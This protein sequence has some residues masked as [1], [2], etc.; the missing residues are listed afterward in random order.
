MSPS[1]RWPT[2]FRIDP[3]LLLVPGAL[4]LAAEI[5]IRSWFAAWA[6]SD[7]IR[8]QRLAHGMRHAYGRCLV[9][10]HAKRIHLHFQAAAIANGNLPVLREPKRLRRRDG[11]IADDRARHDARRQRAILAVEPVRRKPSRAKRRPCASAAFC[12]A[13][14]GNPTTIS[15]AST[16]LTARA[17]APA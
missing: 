14:P 7:A 16:A 11:R 10:M 8:L 5:T 12:I 15:A 1:I 13:D 17:M 9:A 3:A 2:G 6:P 4:I